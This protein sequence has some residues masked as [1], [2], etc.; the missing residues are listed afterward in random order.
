[1]KKTIIIILGGIVFSTLFYTQ[2][3]GINAFIY[4]LFLII[5]LAI[6]RHQILLK[7]TIILSAVGMLASATAIAVHGSAW[8]IVG[9][10]LSTLLFIGY[11]ASHQ[12]S[13]YLSWLNG[14]YNTILGVF[15]SFFYQIEE[16]EITT[17]KKAVDVGQLVKVIFVPLVLVVV[18]TLLYSTANP[19]FSDFLTAIDL[20]FI[21]IFWVFTAVLGALIMANI[22]S[23]QPIIEITDQDINYPNELAPK[24]LNAL[25]LL[26]VKNEKQIGFISIICLNILLVVV[27]ITEVLFI[28]NMSGSSKA[29]VLSDAVHQGVYAS[30]VSII[31]AIGVI[32]FIYRGDLNF[33]KNNEKLRMLTY[34]WIALNALLVISIFIKNYAYITDHGLTHKRIGVLVYLLLTIIGLVTTYLKVSYRLNFVYLIR[35]NMA[36]GYTVIAI[37]GLINWSAIITDHNINV[38]QVDRPYLESLLP[39]NA[40]V[41]KDH[42]LYEEYTKQVYRSGSSRDRYYE[43]KFLNRNW[44]EFNYI[45]YKI[46]QD[47]HEITK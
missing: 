27:L 39:Q 47:Q 20:S 35:R 18:F 8:S 29:S 17:P 2:D 40:L 19:V 36:I 3:L 13:I 10:F 4:S 25:Q 30:I 42:G 14:L 23:P 9:Y 5:A 28:T 11:V 26:A 6:S 38:Q 21:D 24:K 33:I 46:K 44:Q 16:P 7:S 12:T 45:A 43:S 32:A 34:S 37:Y 22:Q 31:L 15:H 1:M 41:L